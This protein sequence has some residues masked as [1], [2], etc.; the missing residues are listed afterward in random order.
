MSRRW[1]KLMLGVL[2]WLPMPAIAATLVTLPWPRPLG[3]ADAL[4]TS[5]LRAVVEDRDGYLWFASDDGLLRFDGHRFRA[6]RREQGLPDVDLRALHVDAQDRLWLATASQGLV[7]ISADRRVIQSVAGDGA[8]ALPRTGIG[9]VTSTGDGLLW[10][11]TRT[12]GLFARHPDGHWQAVPMPRHGGHVRQVNALTTD[13]DGRLWVGTPAG[14]FRREKDRWVAVPLADAERGDVQELWPDPEGGVWARTRQAVH[15][16]RGDGALLPIPT[17]S[18]MPVL[19]S[20]EGELWTAGSTGLLRHGPGRTL[21]PV[22]LRGHDGAALRTAA[23]L[24]ALEDR[25]GGLWWIGRGQGL[26]HLPARWRQFTLLPAARDGWPGLDSAHVLALT[27]SRGERV[28]VAGDS[29][30]VQRVDVRSGRSDIGFDYRPQHLPTR[31]V[32]LAEDRRGQVWVTSGTTLSRY[33]PGTGQQR[34]WLLG[35]ESSTGAVDLQACQDGSLWLAW[36]DRIQRRDAD[37]VLQLS[38]VPQTL[39]LVPPTHGP[40]LL[41]T[42]DGV[43]WAADRSGVKR[44]LPAQQRFASVDGAPREEVGAIAHGEDGHYWISSPGMLRR[45]RWDGQQLR[46][47]HSFGV[48]HGYP[49]LLARALVV[50]AGG[51]AWA[52]DARGLIRVDPHGGGVRRFGSDDGLPVHAVMPRRLVRTAGNHV[53]AAA[54][55]G[56][57]LLFDPVAVLRPA[58]TPGLVVHAITARRGKAQITLPVGAGPVPLSGADRH[59]RVAARLLSGGEPSHVRYRFRLHGHDADWQESGAAGLRVFERLPVGLQSLE[60]Q[61]RQGDAGWSPIRRVALQ[62]TPAWWQT[63]P[64]RWTAAAAVVGVVWVG[65]WGYHAH[66]RRQRRWRR[67]HARQQRAERASVQRT[68][69]LTTLGARIRVPMTAVLGWSELLLRA[70]LAP[71]ERSR[72]NSLHYAGEHLLR[73]MDD[74]LDMASIESGQLQLQP[75]PFVLQRLIE[76]LHALLLPVAQGK[77]LV[78]EWHSSV[79]A[80]ACFLGDAPR[81]RQ[82][83]LNLL[84]NALKF[85]AQGTVRLEAQ[86]GDGG[87]GV[88][89]RVRDTGPGMTPTQCQRLFQRFEQADGAQTTARYGGT[90]LGLAIS[91]DLALA[92]GGDIMVTSRPG[93]GAC[94]Q[95]R[96]PLP[97]GEAVAG[98]APLHGRPEPL[99]A[100]TLRVLVVYPSP[101][102]AEVLLAMLA[103]LGH[104]ALCVPGLEGMPQTAGDGACWD[105]IVVDPGLCLDD[106]RAGARLSRCWPGVPRLALSPRADTGAQRAVIA[107]GFDMFLRLPVSRTTLADG[108]ARC[109]R[110][111]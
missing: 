62:V 1:A 82:I 14:A 33:V 9:Q 63:P 73:L 18:A 67:L 5:A 79:P 91:R 60:V 44:W 70:P 84:G 89:L 45:Y 15:R 90:G 27:P 92:M 87:E 109:R 43:L 12:D 66:L 110:V 30:R 49:R 102:V 77:A 57:L 61:A 74:A 99:G 98:T 107:A 7:K 31:A 72:V 41:C 101:S 93:E 97:R 51:I 81:L 2:L 37:G 50:D 86:P 53:V 29:G 10:V 32:G 3:P 21:Q 96:L 78:L 71:A 52:G 54:H 28:W 38:A 39:G 69:F 95:V 4:P 48:V 24:G 103:S 34:H 46:K 16:W 111:A 47:T 35:G 85:T 17:G 40:Q 83:L 106:E 88:L 65:G 20:T 56:G 59:V 64:A 55:E 58:R 108:L 13:R 76:E 22:P 68:R 19:R 75:A 26:W 105:V 80:S 94:F 8:V 104:L 25:V 42:S 100:R 23:V 11:G 6:W 36:Q